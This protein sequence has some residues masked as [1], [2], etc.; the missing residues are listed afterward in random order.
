[1]ENQYLMIAENITFKHAKLSCINI[2]DQF[3]GMKLP[4]EFFFDMVVICGPGWATGE[5]DLS[6]RAKTNEMDETEIG[7]IKA[8]IKNESFVYNA[9]AEN[10]KMSFGDDIESVVFSVYRNGEKFLERKYPVN[11][12]LVKAEANA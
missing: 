1:M 7:S 8:E 9:V 2:I 5:Y 4:A 10:I 11:A 6:I 12:L 3:T